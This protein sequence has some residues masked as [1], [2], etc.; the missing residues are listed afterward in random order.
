MSLRYTGFWL[1]SWL[2]HRLPTASAFDLAER[3]ADLWWRS[4]ANERAIIEAN[5]AL[6]AGAA[7][8]EHAGM[9]REVFRNFGRYLVEFFSVHRVRGPEL[10]V[11]GYE[12][13]VSAQQEHHGVIVLTGHLGNWEVGGV[14]IQRMGFPM[15]VVA[16]PHQDPRTDDLFNRQRERCGLTVIPLGRGAAH[17]SLECLRNGEVLGVLGDR[18]FNGS[19]LTVALCGRQALFPLGPAILSLRSRA[20]IVPTFLIR[21]GPWKFR[22]CFEPPIRPEPALGEKPSVRSLCQRFTRVFERYL[23]QFPAQWLMFK[24]LTGT[25]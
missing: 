1:T 4:A 18:E 20:P 2:S 24:P 10:Q 21:E 11:E 14:V 16:L 23:Q 7:P 3:L 9:S 12:H 6:I 15:S 5:L 17:R 25:G 19:G 22:L 13:L 8:R